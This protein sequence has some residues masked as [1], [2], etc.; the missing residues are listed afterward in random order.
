M[1]EE[2]KEKPGWFMSIRKMPTDQGFSYPFF[3]W[4]YGLGNF[5]GGELQAWPS[6]GGMLVFI[7][8]RQPPTM[9][10]G[11]W[12]FTSAKDALGQVNL[13]GWGD[14]PPPH[15]DE[16]FQTIQELNKKLPAG[17]KE[18]VIRLFEELRQKWQP[19]VTS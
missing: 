2:T 1:A 12:K 16:V 5:R 4:S 13:Y 8:R 15:V 14:P 3:E 11:G 9:P 6:G 7:D 10:K 18:E 17:S 19:L